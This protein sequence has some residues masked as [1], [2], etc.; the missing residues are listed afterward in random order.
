MANL[1]QISDSDFENEV[2]KSNVPVLLDFWAEWCAPCRALGPMLEEVAHEFGTKV[3]IVK[4]NIDENPD[5]PSNFGVRSIPTMILFK[6]GQ[7]VDQL[8]GR[9]MTKD[10]IADMITKV[11]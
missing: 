7:P 10:P 5:T 6:G 1:K 8:I 2:L 9:P 11:L 3:K 4:M